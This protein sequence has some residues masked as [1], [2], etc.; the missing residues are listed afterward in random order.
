MSNIWLINISSTSLQLKTF[1]I[2]LSHIEVRMAS[3]TYE[4]RRPSR[5][6]SSRTSRNDDFSNPSLEE[7]TPAE[8]EMRPLPPTDRGKDAY[9]VL[10]GCTIIQ[11]PV[12]GEQWLFF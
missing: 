6:Q 7:N 5:S 9:L 12:W 3:S 10:L 4:M 11:A 1:F 8:I 2:L